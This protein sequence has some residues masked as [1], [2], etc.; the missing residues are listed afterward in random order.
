MTPTPASSFWASRSVDGLLRPFNGLRTVAELYPEVIDF[1]KEE[2]GDPSCS[3][4]EALTRQQP[5]LNQA[6]AAQAL[7]LLSRLHGSIDYHGAFLNLAT[8][9]TTPLPID[10]KQWQRL[11]RWNRRAA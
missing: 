5:F 7:A 6:L 10:P 1:A 9:K 8:G 11:S 4:L 2:P 3:A